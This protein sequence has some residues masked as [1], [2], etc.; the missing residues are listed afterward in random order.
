LHDPEATARAHN[1]NCFFRTGDIAR[2]EGRHYSIVGR[3]SLHISKTGGYKF[4]ALDIKRELLALPHLAEAIVGDVD[5]DEFR[6]RVAALLS[7]HDEKLRDS[8]LK[9]YGSSEHI[10][11][12]A[13]LRKNLRGGLA[14]FKLPTLL[15]I[16]E[17]ELSKLATGKIQ[18]KLLGPQ[19]FSRRLP[20]DR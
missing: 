10:L 20:P 9:T 15:R 11:T 1:E 13:D 4:S 14:G 5:D 3:A 17:G 2:R 8:F 19:F 18:K 16:V 12:L 6:Q 7:L